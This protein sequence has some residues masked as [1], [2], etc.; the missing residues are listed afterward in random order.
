MD[1]PDFEKWFIGASNIG[2]TEC[3]VL[4]QKA[5]DEWLYKKKVIYFDELYWS[6]KEDELFK[7]KAEFKGRLVWEKELKKD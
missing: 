7:H 5:F 4:A 2:E 6:I 1:R 3:A